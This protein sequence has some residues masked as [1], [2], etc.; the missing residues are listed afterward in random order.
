MISYELRTSYSTNLYYTKF[1]WNHVTVLY[2]AQV[3]WKSIMNN[4]FIL[5]YASYKIEKNKW[6]KKKIF[7]TL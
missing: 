4:L 5:D 2:D 1:F 7:L 3:Y 6:Y